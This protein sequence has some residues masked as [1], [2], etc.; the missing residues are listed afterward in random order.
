VNN[1]IVNI[2]IVGGGW[3]VE[4]AHIP[5]LQNNNGVNLKAVFDTNSERAHQ[6]CN[7][8]GIPYAFDKFEALLTCG[9]DGIIIATPN[10]THVDYTLVALKHGISVLCEKP[11][12]F[13]ADEVK[14]I[15]KASKENNAV[16]VPGFVNYWRQ[17]IQSILKAISSGKVGEVKNISAGWLRRCGVPRPGTWFTNRK[18]SG[19][20][21][22]TDLGS[23]VLPICLM[24]L[25][26][27]NLVECQM[28]T[29][30]CDYEKIKK[31]GAAEWFKSDDQ[32]QYNMDVEDT[33]I[34]DVKF[35]D[36]ST[37]HVKLSW[38]APVSADCTYF[39]VIGTKG[40][41]ELQ[42]LFGFSNERLWEEDTLVTE[43]DGVQEKLFLNK[44]ENNTR[45]AF[46]QMIDFFVQA[47]SNKT[48]SLIEESVVLSAVS[49]IEKLYKNDKQNSEALKML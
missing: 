42:T 46:Q 40:K 38:S 39:T 2:G 12:A 29:S 48:A 35:E 10:F 7:Q 14:E 23:H 9:I 31:A 19:G 6:L 16:Y 36:N 37:M 21:V 25:G 15:I 41:I 33:A 43:Y 27:K 11:I 45:N 44:E 5:A 3:I 34:V 30:V 49:L 47:V 4:H 1:K 28:I 32:N 18:F 8:F 26:K 17:D 22:L 13:H 20:G 24:M